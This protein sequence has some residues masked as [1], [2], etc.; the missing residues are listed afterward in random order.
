MRFT[1]RRV[2]GTNLVFDETGHQIAMF[3]HTPAGVV[4]FASFQ[5]GLR[6]AGHTLEKE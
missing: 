6:G 1:Y 5:S 3:A 2:L 4:A